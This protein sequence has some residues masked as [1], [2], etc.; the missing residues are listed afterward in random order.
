MRTRPSGAIMH[1]RCGDSRGVCWMFG[2]LHSV[3]PVTVVSS[4]YLECS[5]P[6]SPIIFIHLSPKEDK[7]FWALFHATKSGMAGCFRRPRC[8]VFVEG[9][10]VLPVR[11]QS[12]LPS[13]PKNSRSW[14]GEPQL[15]SE[16]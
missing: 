10:F 4:P 3:L 11:G 12:F 15:I 6:S 8:S 7:V 9:R 16:C 5:L 13:K 14:S 1:S 2:E